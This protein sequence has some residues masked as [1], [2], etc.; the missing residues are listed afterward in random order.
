MSSDIL[1][2]VDGGSTL[3]S[4]PGPTES[5][6]SAMAEKHDLSHTGLWAACDDL[7]YNH[8]D[9][10]KYYD[11]TSLTKTDLPRRT[12]WKSISTLKISSHTT[13][14]AIWTSAN[15]FLTIHWDPAEDDRPA[16]TVFYSPSSG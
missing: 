6:L 16:N 4:I 3:E 7:Q 13:L 11:D 9:C 12:E 8:V 10:I 5:C 1:L 15:K 2:L 14:N